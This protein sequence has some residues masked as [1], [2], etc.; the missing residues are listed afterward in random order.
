MNRYV[1]RE[2]E[3]ECA[4]LNFYFDNDCFNANS[5]DYNNTIFPVSWSH[6]MKTCGINEDEYDDLQSEMSNIFYDVSQEIGYGYKN[7]KEV[8]KDYKLHYS[9]KNA[10]LLKEIAEL[11]ERKPEVM[12]QYLGIKTGK[13]WDTRTCNGYC[14]SDW[15]VIVYCTEN[16]N[17][18]AIDEIGDVYLGCAKEFG[19]HEFNDDDE[20]INTCY[21]FIVADSTAW[22]PEDI[23]S[24]LCKWE[25][26]NPDE[27]T[28]E[29]IENSR[30]VTQY[31]YG[32]Y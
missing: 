4:E 12:A 11:D 9:P 29:L 21:G 28:L 30:T 23:K 31:S 13:K 32:T 7:V 17:E 16:Y 20:E 22:K 19:L 15:C 10:H 1:F 18:K 6:N 5:G 27:V 26:L 3:P 24:V 8:M 2:V 14:Q 25:G